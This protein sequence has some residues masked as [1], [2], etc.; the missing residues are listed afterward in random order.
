MY[1]ALGIIGLVLALVGIYALKFC[2]VQTPAGHVTLIRKMGGDAVDAKRPGFSWII[3]P[4]Y[5]ILEVV[6]IKRYTTNI[7]PPK[8]SLQCMENDKTDDRSL[9]LAEA[10][11]SSVEMGEVSL[12]YELDF[13]VKGTDPNRPVDPQ[14]LNNYFK[15][16]GEDGKVTPQSVGEFLKDIIHKFFRIE[17]SMLG[18]MT[19]LALKEDVV[20]AVEDGL[21]TTIEKQHFSLV[22]ISL[23]MNESFTPTDRQLSALMEEKVRNAAKL[24]AD[25][26]RLANETFIAEQ[27]VNLARLKGAANKA[28]M[29][30]QAEGWG[31]GELTG[32]ARRQAQ[33]EVERIKAQQMMAQNPSAKMV[34]GGG[35]SGQNS[36]QPDMSAFA[37]MLMMQQSQNTDPKKPEDGGE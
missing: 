11:V 34:I 6:Q 26:D 8:K 12:A 36:Q 17:V 20:M 13:W 29:D 32:E 18:V 19:V 30:A 2:L 7:P 31:F 22:V 37:A 3:W 15:M 9:N 23:I 1:L 16:K 5:E 14:K 35:G 25:R 27:E 24:S 4:L 21:V 10:A 33:N 28:L